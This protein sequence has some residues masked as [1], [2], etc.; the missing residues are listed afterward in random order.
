M[1]KV[2]IA[3]GRG[4]STKVFEAEYLAEIQLGLYNGGWINSAD[5]TVAAEVRAPNIQ[6]NSKWSSF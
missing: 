4:G 6:A 1:C 5:A 3:S 2:G